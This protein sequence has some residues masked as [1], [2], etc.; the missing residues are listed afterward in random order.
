MPGF[1]DPVCE[2]CRDQ[3]NASTL[4]PATR[5]NP[6]NAR[7]HALHAVARSCE[8][9]WRTSRQGVGSTPVGIAVVRHRCFLKG[10]AEGQLTSCHSAQHA[11]DMTTYVLREPAQAVQ[12]ELHQNEKEIA[13]LVE[14]TGRRA[15]FSNDRGYLRFYNDGPD[16]NIEDGMW[17]TL[18]G[19]DV[20]VMTDDKFRATFAP[21]T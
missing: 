9:C 4:F 14:S 6:A 7:R 11:N 18:I 20:A 12:Y 5:L 2:S 19:G 21:A 17:V 3:V 1:Q 13:A 8:R 15:S 16:L 10:R